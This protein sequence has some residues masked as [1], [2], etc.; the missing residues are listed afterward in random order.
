V[1]AAD[2]EALQIPVGIAFLLRP[3]PFGG[4]VGFYPGADGAMESLPSL[5]AWDAIRRRSAAA[6]SV[7]A[8]TE[9]LLLRRLADGRFRAC[10]APIDRCYELVGRIH[11]FWRGSDGG[12]EARAEIER[13]FE[14][15][16][17]PAETR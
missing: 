17:A 6:G 14:A 1:S 11:R 16:N 13:F 10:I 9:A 12:D 8:D 5:D 15:L 2:W 3:S 7:A 4:V